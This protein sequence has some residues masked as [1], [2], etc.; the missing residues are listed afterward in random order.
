VSYN[1][2]ASLASKV[3]LGTAPMMVSI[4]SPV[5]A[6]ER[7]R[8]REGGREG[9]GERGKQEEME[10]GEERGSEKKRLEFRLEF[11]LGFIVLGAWE[12]FEFGAPCNGFR[13]L[14]QGLEFRYMPHHF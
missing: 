6:P 12:G 10:R 1:F 8:D 9:G 5:S 4:R 2:C 7:A 3:A 14:V 13:V 11:R